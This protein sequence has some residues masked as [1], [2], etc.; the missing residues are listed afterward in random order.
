M[1]VSMTGFGRCR[2]ESGQ[3]TITVEVKTVNHR[4]FELN[5]RIP[6]E[7]LPLED[8]I[9]KKLNEYI[10]RGR[11]ELFISIKGSD[12]LKTKVNVDWSFLEAYWQAVS[13]IKNKLRLQEEISL[14]SILNQEGIISCDEEF[15]GDKEWEDAIIS[16][17]DEAAKQV[18]EMRLAEGEA[19]EKDILSSLELLGE[20]CTMLEQLAPIVVKHYEERLKK[21]M[22]ELAKGQVDEMRLINEVAIFADKADISEELARINSHIAQFNKIIKSNGPIGRKLDFL[23]QE[24]NREANTIGS[25]GNDSNIAVLVVEMKSLI[26]KMKEQVQNIE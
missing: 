18:K 10:S 2:T 25:K 23:L 1:A 9:R 19:L 17:V 7:L 6:R 14:Q 20:K 24:M 15:T 22:E 26:E 4:F 11:V 16:A 3:T 5:S 21:R 8:K 12:H 13:A